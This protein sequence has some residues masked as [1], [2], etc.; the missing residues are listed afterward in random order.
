[1]YQD[2]KDVDRSN[3]VNMKDLNSMFQSTKHINGSNLVNIKDPKSTY[4]GTKDVDGSNLVNI[5]DPNSMHQG[6]KDVDESNLVNVKEPSPALCRELKQPQPVKLKPTQDFELK[7]VNN[8]EVFK[9]VKDIEVTKVMEESK[10]VNVEDS[11]AAEGTEW[12]QERGMEYRSIPTAE[13]LK[14]AKDIEVVK[15]KLNELEYKLSKVGLSGKTYS[16]YLWSN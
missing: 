4:Q 1:M 2:I 8:P 14:L 3:L 12:K 6:A 13:G 7:T 15:T 11:K 10:M 5:K 16:Q 9:L